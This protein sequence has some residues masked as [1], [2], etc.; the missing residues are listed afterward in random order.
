MDIL[1]RT[2]TLVSEV[3]HYPLILTKYIKSGTE[4]VINRALTTYQEVVSINYPD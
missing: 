3:R 1:A 2:A 4:R